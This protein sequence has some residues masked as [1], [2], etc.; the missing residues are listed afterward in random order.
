[1][2]RVPANA[3]TISTAKNSTSGNVC[4]CLL[5][6]L[7]AWPVNGFTAVFTTASVVP[8]VVATAVVETAVVVGVLV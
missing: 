1:M 8:V 5:T 7:T 6:V 3:S 4:A 2:R